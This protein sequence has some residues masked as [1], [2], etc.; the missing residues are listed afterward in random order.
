MQAWRDV[1]LNRR[2]EGIADLSVQVLSDPGGVA[3]TIYSDDGITVAT[4]PLTTAS[5]GSY[6]FYAAN[7]KYQVVISGT[8]ITTK[9]LRGIVLDDNASGALSMLS[10]TAGG[11][12]D[13]LTATYTGA[14]L[15]DGL[16]VNL[17]AISANAT[18]A[19]TFAFSGGAAVAIKK[20]GN[21][22]V[23]VGQWGPNWELE[24]RYVAAGPRWELVNATGRTA[25]GTARTYYVDTALGNDANTGLAAGSG[26]AFKT[27]QKAVDTVCDT[28]IASAQIT[29]QLADGTYNENITLKRH[30]CGGIAGQSSVKVIGNAANNTGVVLNSTSGDTISGVAVDTPFWFKNIKI[31]SAAGIGVLAD[32]GSVIYLD[33]VNFGACAS[34]HVLSEWGSKVEFINNGY[35]ISGG[36]VTHCYAT[37]GSMILMQGGKTVT[38]S[39]G[40]TFSAYFVYAGAGC[41]V[42]ISATT[43]YSGATNGTQAQ[44]DSGGRVYSPNLL[45]GPGAGTP[46]PLNADYK[47]SEVL[48]GAA[49]ALANAVVKDVTTLTLTPGEWDVWFNA[50]TKGNAATTV[51][52]LGASISNGAATTFNNVADAAAWV[53]P[54]NLTVFAFSN[55]LSAKVGPY[56]IKLTANATIYGNVLSGFAVNTQNVYGKLRARRLGEYAL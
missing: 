14:T 11:S 52:Y 24:L 23:D 5:D 34:H 8:N 33:N 29:I 30:F 42:D 27:L 10:Q 47:E 22:S 25:L 4:N 6:S 13:A 17:R 35:T 36:A 49:L 12:A 31:T 39:G 2:G 28:I 41:I 7:G 53:V 40:P 55:D 26:S 16:Q 54:G 18:A 20:Y 46:G 3:A 44:S 50:V 15:A 19:P 56:R 37:R 9:T 32:F 38:I 1:E 48:T 43:T 45:P 21:V 51:G